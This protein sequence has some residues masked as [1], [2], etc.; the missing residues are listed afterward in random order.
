MN[1]KELQPSAVVQWFA[2]RLHEHMLG[3]SCP[4]CFSLGY[5]ISAGDQK[6]DHSVT[7]LQST[8]SWFLLSVTLLPLYAAVSPSD[9]VNIDYAYCTLK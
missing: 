4:G 5:F 6:T 8:P 3:R 2:R 7:A 1:L 9:L